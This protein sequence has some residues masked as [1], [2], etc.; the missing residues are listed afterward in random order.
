M[1]NKTP[2]NIKKLHVGCGTKYWDE[3]IN[4]DLGDEDSYG[5]KIK[6]DYR[7]DL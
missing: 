3:W 7:H 2:E 6:V 4:L 5:N 1:Q